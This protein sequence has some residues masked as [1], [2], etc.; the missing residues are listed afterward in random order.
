MKTRSAKNKGQRAC[1]QAKSLILKYFSSLKDEDVIVTP[2]GV[3]GEDLK[4]SPL[5]RSFL[6]FAFEV[7]NQEKLNVL[8]AYKQ[9]CGHTKEYIPL[10]V[11]TKNREDIYAT[12][13]FEDLLSLLTP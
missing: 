6:P 1:K 10:V 12:L 5:A 4:L 11:H 13:K 8:Q 2:S 9:A 3:T 7:K